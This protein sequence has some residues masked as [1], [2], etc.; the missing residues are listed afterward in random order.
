[1]SVIGPWDQIIARNASPHHTIP[2]FSIYADVSSE[3]GTT[4]KDHRIVWKLGSPENNGRSHVYDGFEFKII[5]Y[6]CC[7]HLL[8]HQL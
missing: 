6:C 4:F 2:G 1:M 3:S 7:P 5:S 8:S